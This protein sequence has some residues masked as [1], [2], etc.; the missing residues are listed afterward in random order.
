MDS[1]LVDGAM[2]SLKS[3]MDMTH[4]GLMKHQ[5]TPPGTQA[6]SKR[7]LAAMYK[8]LEQSPPE[9]REA[10]LKELTGVLGHEQVI[11]FLLAMKRNR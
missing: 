2:D 5:S 8:N 9:V 10:K 11:K 3:F 6:R 4:E 1:G 7:E